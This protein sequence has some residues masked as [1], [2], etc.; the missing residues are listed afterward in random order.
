MDD[1][2]ISGREVAKRY[3]IAL[4]TL[5][6]RV[7]RGDLRAFKHPLD[8]RMRLYRVADIERLLQPVPEPISTP[9][10]AAQ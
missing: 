3:G 10:A 1:D 9:K 7:E 8:D 4:L 5:R 2:F 6:R